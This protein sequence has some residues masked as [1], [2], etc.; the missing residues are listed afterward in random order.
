M[1]TAAP[2]TPQEAAHEVVLDIEGMTCA[3][4][5]A[6][7][8]KVLRRT[9]AVIDARV[10][11]ASRQATVQTSG[12]GV[13]VLVAAV[14]RAGYGAREH[15][16]TRTPD[17]E[18]RD[19]LQRLVVAVVFTVPILWLTF[20][21]SHVAHGMVWTWVL[22]TP[23]QF[24]AGWPFLRSAVRAAR[25]GASTMDT[26]I[27]IGSSTAYGY[28]AW[29]TVAG[30]DDHSFD[31]AA[32]IITLILVGKVLE[33]R[34]RARAGDAAR[35]LLERGAR[36]ATLLVGG[37]E[38]TV[39]AGD[40]R[41]G[42]HVVVRP[43]ATV[44]VD[45][46]VLTGS[47]SIDVAHLTGESV[48]LDVAADD[49]VIGGS[50]NGAGVFVVEARRVG[51]ETA[52]AGIVRLLQETQGSKAP[53]QRLADRISAVFVP[54]VLALAAATFAGWVLVGHAALGAA[55]LHSVAV[56]VIA[57]P[58][59]LGLATPAAV[60]AGSG[61][62]AEL[63]ILFRGAEVFEAARSL[64]VVVLDKTGTVT[65]GAMRLVE[66]VPGPTITDTQLLVLA[67]ATEMGSE[68]PIARAVVRGANDRGI[69][70]PVASRFV[71]I[72]GAGAEADVDGHHIVVGRADDVEGELA[73]HAERIAARGVTVFAVWSDGLPIGVL[74]VADT[75]KPSSADAV[76]RLRS[77]GLGVALLTGDRRTTSL[78]VADALG[79]DDVV[80]G[81]LPDEKVAD[82][83]RR[84]AA[85][86]HVGF[87]GDGIN[88]G[89][90]LARADV[91]I[92]LGSGADVA[93][94]AAT[95]TLPGGDLHG[96]ADAVEVARAT[97]RVI[98][99]NLLWAFGYNV[100]MIPLAVA[101]VLQPTWAAGAMA[102][103]SVT[104]VG[105]A[106][107]LRRF[108]RHVTTAPAL[109]SADHVPVARAV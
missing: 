9:P 72:P 10:N 60:M 29:A 69:L 28:S 20:V 109:P 36:T 63:G 97:F 3:S 103:S 8:E 30:R 22:A 35:A 90:A 43:G 81:V 85:G 40:V 78:A 2:A 65:E 59:A 66:V 84:Q 24:Y 42:D 48:P 4:C 106:L 50:I 87:V 107:R 19:Y 94:E 53:V 68:H 70:V 32:V 14:K 56:V 89:A 108:R 82:I 5:V 26:L 101:G 98:R 74:G 93:I 17:D 33:A 104:V 86:H 18:S 55:L 73:A 39:P 12:A 21:D 51:A 88:D 49:E 34:A 57:C 105:N 95:I 71:A 83:A 27:A 79:I 46:V 13:D 23:V 31:T 41:V 58:C 11:L 54:V 91:G 99:Q 67:A 7:I 62:A 25:H 76:Q 37:N 92:A 64:D 38:V 45:G 100:V 75:L 1:T 61:R 77:L 96:V 16:A 6:R 47:S 102:A 15:V 80:A 44:P 52:L